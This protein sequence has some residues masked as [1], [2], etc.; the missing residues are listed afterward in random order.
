[1]KTI[2]KLRNLAARLAMM[3]VVGATAM[4]ATSCDDYLNIQPKSVY[5]PETLEDYEAFFNNT[6]ATTSAH[7][8]YEFFHGYLLGERYVSKATLAWYPQEDYT[9]IY[10]L[11]TD[12]DRSLILS[13]TEIQMPY[14]GV[15]VANQ[16]IDGCNSVDNCDEGYRQSLI[17]SARTLRAMMLFRIAQSFADAYNPATAATKMAIPMLT[18]SSASARVVQPTLEEFYKFLV[19]ELEEAA[20]CPTLENYGHTI[21]IPGKGAAYAALARVKLAMWDYE[22]ALDAANKALAINSQLIDWVKFYNDNYENYFKEYVRGKYL[23]S[24]RDFAAVDNYYYAMNTL[25]LSNGSES[26][27]ISHRDL[28]EEGDRFF[29]CHWHLPEGYNYYYQVLSGRVNFAGLSTPE[30][31]YIKAECLARLGK[32]SD[33]CDVINAHRRTVIDPAVYV[34]FK[35][36]SQDEC[37]RKVQQMKRGV[38]C[39]NI[40]NL[41]DIKRY[42]SEGKYPVTVTK[43]Y[44]DGTVLTLEPNHRLYTCPFP[45]NLFGEGEMYGNIVQNA[46]Y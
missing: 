38:C 13:S 25:S 43:T 46:E 17:A 16:I 20:A 30:Q 40:V 45:L 44:E 34:D 19:S 4:F 42:N 35:T 9:Y 39:K 31:Y 27:F 37:I 1:M 29:D 41:S 28:Y 15:T 32:V 22:G 14:R 8:Y 7:S 10:S 23:P 18:S 6:G 5:I 2:Y 12:Y 36:T 21:L 11:N 3:T 24:P 26:M 33:A